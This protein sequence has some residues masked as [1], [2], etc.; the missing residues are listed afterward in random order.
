MIRKIDWKAYLERIGYRGPTRPSVEV[1]QRLHTR[2]LLSVLFENLDIHLDRPIVLSEV[3]FFDKINEHRRGGFRYELNG[4]FATLLE[5]LGFRVSMLSAR[6]A[7]KDGG[8]SPDFDHMT[9][10]VRLKERWLAD[11]GF[12]DLFT[13]PDFSTL[14][15]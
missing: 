2:R 5:G 10:L 9:L 12:R 1:L 8:F 4:F 15:P 14:R 3:A 13:G 7:R 11:V 6:V